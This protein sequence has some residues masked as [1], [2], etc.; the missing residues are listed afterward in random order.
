[1]MID[2]A[3]KIDPRAG[4]PFMKARDQSHNGFS[5]RRVVEQPRDAYSSPDGT[6]SPDRNIVA[7]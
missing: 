3:G 5:P 7:G 6:T 1:M 4:P 2:A